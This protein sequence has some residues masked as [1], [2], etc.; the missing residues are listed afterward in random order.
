MLTGSNT[1]DQADSQTGSL[2]SLRRTVAGPIAELNGD[3]NQRESGKVKGSE[4]GIKRLVEAD[5][6]QVESYLVSKGLNPSQIQAV[7]NAAVV[8]KD[9]NYN[10]HDHDK[11][12]NNPRYQGRG[13][14]AKRRE[15]VIRLIQGPPGTGK[16][17]TLVRLLS[18]VLGSN[19][20]IQV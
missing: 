15:K 10:E 8:N 12:S 16:T 20:Y 19:P 4:S 5:P 7:L 6:A 3:I 14:V 1:A 18:V 9:V 17:S 13:G 2:P 11:N